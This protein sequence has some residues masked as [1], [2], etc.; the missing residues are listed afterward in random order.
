MDLLLKL[1]IYFIKHLESK[2]MISIAAF[3]AVIE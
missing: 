3:I 1:S 2:Q